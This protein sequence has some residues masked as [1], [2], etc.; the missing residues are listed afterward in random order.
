[1]TYKNL[2]SLV[3]VS[4]IGAVLIASPAQARLAAV[5]VGTAVVVGTVVAVGMEVLAL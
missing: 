1:M 5:A 4:I 3:V 2:A